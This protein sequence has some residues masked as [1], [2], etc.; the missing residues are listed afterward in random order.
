MMATVLFA[1][2]VF[3]F[4]AYIYPCAVTERELVQLFLWNG[5]YFMERVVVPGGL[6]RYVGEWL[7]QYFYYIRNGAIIYAHLFA[8]VQWLAARILRKA[9]LFPLSFLPALLLWWMAT[10]MRFPMTF[11]IALLMVLAVMALLPASRRQS[12][13]ATAVLVPVMY[14]A[15][16][17]VA[18]LLVIYHLRWI[19]ERSA[20]WSAVG[21]TAGLALLF[22][23]CLVGSARLA[24]YSLRSLAEGIDYSWHTNRIGT[25]EDMEFCTLLRRGQWEKIIDKAV[26]KT[27][28]SAASQNVACLALWQ[29]KRIGENELIAAMNHG[30]SVMADAVTASMVS[31]L[32]MHI[33]MLNMSQ[34]AAFE[35]MES[36]TNNNKSGRA[37]KRLAEV[38]LFTGQYEVA[39][40][41]LR[42]LEQTVFYRKWAESMRPYLKHPELMH[43]DPHYRSYLD[44]YSKTNDIF[45]Y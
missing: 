38:A 19:G 33:G 21:W 14:W 32:Y 17:P 7:V 23:F 28:E 43:S 39:A 3:C 25:Y 18:M 1:I 36:V 10:D 41:Y 16:G 22:A 6:A 30:R 12:L 35:L 4:W 13:I 31:D 37:V 26:K 11:H 29:T 40:K 2:A 20:R 44:I 15:A 42:L 9:W 5:D 24:P 45:F 34:R 27:P 8:A